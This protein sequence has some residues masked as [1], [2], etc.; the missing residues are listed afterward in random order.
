MDTI[1]L[2]ISTEEL[3]EEN[4]VYQALHEGHRGNWLELHVFSPETDDCEAFEC[5]VV[6][7]ARRRTP[8]HRLFLLIPPLAVRPHI[9]VERRL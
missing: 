7:S 5:E 2:A 3:Q 1:R 4:S 8:R 9:A 6:F